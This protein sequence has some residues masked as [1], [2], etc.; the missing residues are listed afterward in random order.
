MWWLFIIAC[1]FENKYAFV[2]FNKGIILIKYYD[3]QKYK[4][5]E[6]KRCSLMVYPRNR[7]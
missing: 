4:K 2:V 1:L 3:N 5:V 6:L 7:G